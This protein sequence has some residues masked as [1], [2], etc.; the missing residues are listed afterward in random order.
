[1]WDEDIEGGT[2]ITI[3]GSCICGDLNLG[4]AWQNTCLSKRVILPA[5]KYVVRSA[6]PVALKEVT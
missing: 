6:L 1:M 5:W 4:L 2:S 3:V